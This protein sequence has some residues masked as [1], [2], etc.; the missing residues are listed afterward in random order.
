L[1]VAAAHRGGAAAIQNPGSSNQHQE[2]G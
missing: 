2:R 1:P